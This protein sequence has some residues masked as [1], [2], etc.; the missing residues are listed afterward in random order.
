MRDSRK[1]VTVKKQKRKTEKNYF[2]C[3]LLLAWRR[4]KC[5]LKGRTT[6]VRGRVGSIFD[7]AE[8]FMQTPLHLDI[9]NGRKLEY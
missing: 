9:L 6:K 1:T 5:L 4:L 3:L 8:C 2:L 7:D